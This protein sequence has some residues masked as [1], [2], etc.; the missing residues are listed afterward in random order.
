MNEKNASRFEIEIKKMHHDS[1]GAK[2]RKRFACS[3]MNFDI[4]AFSKYPGIL[5]NLIFRM[6]RI[7][8]TLLNVQPF[9]HLFY[10]PTYI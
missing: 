7:F 2:E 5:Y 4:V 8:S 9:H 10:S 6:N 3:I 1:L